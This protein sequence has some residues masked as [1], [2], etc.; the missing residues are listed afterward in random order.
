MLYDM[1]LFPHVEVYHSCYI[2]IHHR[3]IRP[4]PTLFYCYEFVI[5]IFGLLNPFFNGRFIWV[6]THRFVLIEFVYFFPRL[7]VIYENGMCAH[8]TTKCVCVCMCVC[9]C[10]F[11]YVCM[12][13]CVCVCVF[14]G[15]GGGF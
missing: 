1:V 9:G 6:Y 3:F 8:C 13:M 4:P 10:I 12:K 2:D 5:S 7:L 11:V 15:G 14:V